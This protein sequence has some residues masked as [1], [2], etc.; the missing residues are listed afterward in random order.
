MG[1]TA[2][3]L[4]A[5]SCNLFKPSSK[6]PTYADDL[7]LADG[8]SYDILIKSG[9]SIGKRT[10]GQNP[11]FIAF[12]PRED[13]TSLMWVN[14][15]YPT[16][17]FVSGI[18]RS[19][20]NVKNEREVVGGSVLHVKK[21]DKWEVIK[22][23]PYNRRIDANTK[24][25]FAGDI[26]VAGTNVCVGTFGN[27]AGGVTPWGNILTCEENADQ[28][29]GDPDFKTGGTIPSTNYQWERFFPYPAEHYGWVVEIDPKT[30]VGKKQTGMGRFAHE[31]ATVTVA[32][33][34]RC[35]VYS[36]DDRNDEH[37]YKYIADRPGTL[38]TGSLY[39]A[40][41]KK[42][43]WI[44]LQRE[45]HPVLKKLFKNQLEIQIYT[46]VAAKAVGATPLDRPEDVEVDEKTKN[47]YVALSNNF[48][49]GNY[50]GH[51]LK[52]EERGGDPLS[53][54]MKGSYFAVGGEK[55]GFASPDN[56][57]FDNKGNLW[58]VTDMSGG[59]IGKKPYDKFGN[60]G[61]FKI[62][63][64]GPDAGRAIQMASAPRQSELTGI[65]F[66]NDFKTLFFSVQ[67]PGEKSKS[68]SELE[69]HW[70]GGGDSIPRSA[71]V[72]VKLQ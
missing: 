72:A 1:I 8:L 4:S 42:G 44:S 22:D 18:E 43:K 51:I 54:E 33:D 63:F 61:L 71:V 26:K 59:L 48:G 34:G 41:F 5:S 57:A 68:L 24:F 62:P 21:T 69:S 17:L 32:S 36:G 37:L 6:F 60:N 47:V 9:D 19:L 10:F 29:M 45:D 7:V 12:L 2:G 70:P 15:E 66:S 65:C 23:S 31:S 46:R 14:H 38:D 13:G 49:K 55:S 20:E 35:V 28:F 50:F 27:C 52:V 3:T 16:P 40:D 58:M 67:H 25:S 30:G 11:D 64:S 39:V 53:L 56:L